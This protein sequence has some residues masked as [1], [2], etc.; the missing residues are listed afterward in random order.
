[1]NALLSLIK[2]PYRKIRKFVITQIGKKDPEWLANYLYKKNIGR[3]I[4]WNDPKTLNEKILHLMY[5]GDTSMWPLL[6]DKYG[7]RDYVKQRGCEDILVPIYGKWDKAEDIDYDT[8]PNKFVLKTNH[9]C[10][11]TIIVTDKSKADKQSIAKELNNSLKYQYGLSEAELHYT[12]I[13][14]CI[15]AEQL[16]EPGEEGLVDYKIWCFNGRPKGI[17]VCSDRDMITHHATFN[18][19]NLYWE[20]DDSYLSP[21]NVNGKVL[22]KPQNLEEMLEYASILAKGHPQARVDFYNIKGKIYFGEMTMSSMAGR[23]NYF[24]DKAQLEFGNIIDL[25]YHE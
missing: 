19:Y 1:M 17:F 15:I 7:V 2:K 11:C 20:K 6:A 5:R 4:N 25:D 9:G 13:K 23:M 22:P 24:S 16:L 8:L 10:A 12:K 14:P 21:D 3:D 18:W